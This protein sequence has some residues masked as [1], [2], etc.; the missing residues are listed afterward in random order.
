MADNKLETEERSVVF[1]PAGGSI[2]LNYSSGEKGMLRD[3]HTLRAG[4]LETPG[5]VERRPWDRY[6]TVAFSYSSRLAIVKRPGEP[7][8]EPAFFFQRLSPCY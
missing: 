5:M 7:C 1:L 4:M 3:K 2:V 8:V 6:D